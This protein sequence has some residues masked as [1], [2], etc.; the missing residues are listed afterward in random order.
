MLSS[1]CLGSFCIRLMLSRAPLAFPVPSDQTEGACTEML[2]QAITSSLLAQEGTLE[3]IA[4][5]QSKD[6]TFVSG[7][8][9]LQ[10]RLACSGP[11]RRPCSFI[12]ASQGQ[13]HSCR[14]P[15]AVQPLCCSTCPV[16]KHPEENS[17]TS[18]R[19][20]E[21]PPPCK[22]LSVV[23]THWAAVGQLHQNLFQMCRVLHA[24]LRSH[25]SNSPSQSSV[26][27]SRIGFV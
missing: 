22:M 14:K 1:T 25:A 9:I 23:A 13:P 12:L 20:A 8:I 4:T 18:S 17:W 24:C 19:S 2:V 5:E 15:P 7:Q 26:G 6:P 21:V 27:K 16:E 11:T 3:S 10:V